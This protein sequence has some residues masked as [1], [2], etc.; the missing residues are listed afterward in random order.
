MTTQTAPASTAT[1]PLNMRQLGFCR[2]VVSN[3]GQ[4]T[5]AYEDAG[6]SG[7]G[8][9]GAASRLLA[10]VSVQAEIARLER[11]L[12]IESSVDRA[13]VVTK[14]RNMA[15]NGEKETNRLR[16]TELLGKTLRMFVDVT[17]ATDGNTDA[18]DELKK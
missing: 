3:G 18:P 2:N 15:E 12:E 5:K 9:N 10:N 6:Y 13:Y 11:E 8:A 16:A 1:K 17:V 4:A 7:N 14:L